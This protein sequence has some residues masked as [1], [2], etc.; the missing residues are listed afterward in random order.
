[1][2]PTQLHRPSLARRFGV[3]LVVMLALGLVP[4]AQAGYQA[5]TFTFNI[6]NELGAGNYGTVLV[7]A[8][9]GVAGTF[10]HGLAAGQVRMTVT[11]DWL[12]VYGNQNNAPNFGIQKFGFNTDLNPPPT[13]IVVT[14]SSNTN[15]NWGVAYDKNISEFGTFS[16][17][18]VG[19]GQSRGDPII[20]TI[21][22][23]GGN[24]TLS[25]F[26]FL[27]DTN[28]GQI[29]AYFVAHVAGFPNDPE[30]HYIAVTN[31]TVPTPEPSTVVLALLGA[32]GLGLHR[33]RRR[34]ASA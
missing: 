11:A 16:V 14:N 5:A 17:E 20:V 34:Q 25:H 33:W 12:A 6:S 30:S 13:N 4:A 32:G 10:D 21:S 1:M 29:P 18:D 8:Y 22:D 24:A 2:P 7:E 26:V 9:A 3:P 15:L 27:S 23:L 19:D 31:T 28:N